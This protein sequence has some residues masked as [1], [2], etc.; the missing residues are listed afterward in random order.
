M[1][2]ECPQARG[3][4]RSGAVAQSVGR[5]G[6]NFV[7]RNFRG[8]LGEGGFGGAAPRGEEMGGPQ[9]AFGGDR[10]GGFGGGF[11]ERRSSPPR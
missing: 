7:E 11:H 9:S 8:G 10:A 6:G 5:G 1:S 3:D 2:R 4:G